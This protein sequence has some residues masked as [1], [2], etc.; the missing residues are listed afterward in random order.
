MTETEGLDGESKAVVN[1][2]H[3]LYYDSAADGGTWR[4]T[5]WFGVPTQKC[6]FDMWVYQEILFRLRPDRIIECGT[7]DGGS[8][9]YLAGICDLIGKG[10]VITIDILDIEGRPRHKRIEYLLGSSTSEEVFRG[11]G[12]RIR[13]KDVVM[14]IL[15]SDHSKDHVLK[16][17]KLYS[18]LVTRGS[19]LVV[20]DTNVNGNPILPDFG[21]GPGEAVLEFLQHNN[22]F[23][24]DPCME[25]FYMTFS[26]GGYLLKVR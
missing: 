3:K 19:Y 22:E 9:L 20:E 15:D 24:V 17:M 26:P 11:V 4:N 2:F 23:E 6:P 25:K 8:A 5:Y 16:E 12:N 21:P 10:K 13:R 18:R 14:V 7:A 1:E